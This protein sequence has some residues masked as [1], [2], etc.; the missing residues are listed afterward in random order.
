VC[1]TTAETHRLAADCCLWKDIGAAERW[2]I[3][4]AVEAGATWADQLGVKAP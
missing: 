4:D 1:G 3:A 2:R